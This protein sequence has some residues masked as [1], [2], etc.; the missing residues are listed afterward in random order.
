[1]TR[2]PTDPETGGDPACWAHLFEDE[3]IADGP[4]PA[5]APPPSVGAMHEIVTALEEQH[6]ELEE[7]L[8]PL[9]DDDWWRPTPRCPGWSIA[10]VVLHLAQTDEIALGSVT[11]RFAEVLGSLTAGLPPTDSIDDGA[12]AMVAAQR[13]RP[14]PEV[15]DRWRAGA[16][17]LCDAFASA[18]PSARVQWVAGDMA[19]RTLATTRLAECWIHTGDVATALG[20]PV[21]ASHRLRHIARLAWRTLPYAFD[22]AGRELTGPV[23]FTLT[24]PDGEVWDLAPDEAVVTTITGTAFDLCQVAGQRADA[25]ETGLTGTGPDAAAILALVRTF[26]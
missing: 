9:S 25:G 14:A 10:D 23:R 3:A 24:G 19:A 12:G 22:R 17:A 7:L 21:P 11:G 13:G 18:D 2:P 16:S 4:G 5:A 15:H 6:D 8:A 1:M 20:R 26:A